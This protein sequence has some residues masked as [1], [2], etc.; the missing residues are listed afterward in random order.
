MVK[1]EKIMNKEENDKRKISNKYEVLTNDTSGDEMEES[2]GEKMEIQEEEKNRIIE[3]S[4][5]VDTDDSEKVVRHKRRLIPVVKLNEK[6]K[7]K[8]D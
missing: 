3:K 1:K 6:K 2:E 4:Q 8:F 5:Q 7:R